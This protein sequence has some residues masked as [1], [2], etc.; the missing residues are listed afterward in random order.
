MTIPVGRAVRDLKL[1]SDLSRGDTLPIHSNPVVTMKTFDASLVENS[2]GTV[3][4]LL[5][6]SRVV[7]QYCTVARELPVGS[8]NYSMVPTS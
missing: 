3:A 4:I 8:D 5:E 7:L 1:V 2:T 6:C